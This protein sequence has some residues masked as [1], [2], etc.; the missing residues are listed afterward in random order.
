V[1]INWQITWQTSLPVSPE[2]GRIIRLLSALARRGQNLAYFDPG[3]I[4][5]IPGPKTKSAIE[6]FEA[7]RA[8]AVT[9][10]YRNEPTLWVIAELQAN[11]AKGN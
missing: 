11:K 2:Q 9:G 5:G 10:N 6:D 8:I 4:D 1:P 3:P 7:S